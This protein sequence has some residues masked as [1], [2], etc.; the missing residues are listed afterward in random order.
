MA[1]EFKEMRKWGAQV[2]REGMSKEAIAAVNEFDGSYKGA[3]ILAGR[4]KAIAQAAGCD[5]YWAVKLRSVVRCRI[6]C[7]LL[8]SARHSKGYGPGI[9]AGM[10]IRRL[11]CWRRP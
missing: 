8:P 11:T 3:M 9:K 5:E 7:C 4:M 10:P 6:I 2:G 1:F